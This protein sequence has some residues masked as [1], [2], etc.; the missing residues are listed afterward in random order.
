[1]FLSWRLLGTDDD[2]RTTFD[3][4]RDDKVIKADLAYVTNYS[5]AQGK[6]GNVY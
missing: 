3:V 1:M 4:I 2:E 5:D 6:S